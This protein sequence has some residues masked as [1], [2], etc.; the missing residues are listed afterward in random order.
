M[1]FGRQM[2]LPIQHRT[3]YYYLQELHDPCVDEVD[4]DDHLEPPSAQE[5]ILQCMTDI[6]NQ[7]PYCSLY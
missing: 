1:M 7:N 4:D 2:T 6:S 3:S 5:V